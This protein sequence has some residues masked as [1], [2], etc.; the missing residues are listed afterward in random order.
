MRREV[1][2]LR[3]I[4]VQ[5]CRRQGIRYEDFLD[6][7][8][9]DILAQA[10]AA[11]WSVKEMATRVLACCCLTD[12]K[13]NNFAAGF[14]TVMTFINEQVRS[15]GEQAYQDLARILQNAGT[16]QAI[17]RWWESNL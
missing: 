14:L 12:G 11:G 7:G 2:A 3:N 13:Y 17:D 4:A 6:R 15:P 5:V 10:D 1:R 16:E 8:L 9:E